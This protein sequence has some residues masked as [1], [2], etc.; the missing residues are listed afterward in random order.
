MIADSGKFRILWL[1]DPI[2]FVHH[3]GR[4]GALTVGL[5]GKGC[6]AF[7]RGCEARNIRSLGA[8]SCLDLGL[9]PESDSP[10]LRVFHGQYSQPKHSRGLPP[11]D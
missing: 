8:G 5:L 9:W 3:K 6:E 4:Y 10:L 2:E 7:K 11:S 1:A